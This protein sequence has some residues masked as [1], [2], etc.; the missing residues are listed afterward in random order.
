MTMIDWP[1]TKIQEK[2]MNWW[3]NECDIEGSGENF[4]LTYEY[5]GR[6]STYNTFEYGFEGMRAK[7]YCD[8]MH[9]WYSYIDWHYEQLGLKE[10]MENWEALEEVYDWEGHHKRELEYMFSEDFHENELFPETT[11]YKHEEVCTG[12]TESVSQVGKFDSNIYDYLSL[13]LPTKPGKRTKEHNKIDKKGIHL[14]MMTKLL[15]KWKPIDINDLF[16]RA[17]IEDNKDWGTELNPMKKPIIT[18]D[19]KDET[20]IEL[21][22]RELKTMIDK[23]CYHEVNMVTKEDEQEEKHYSDE[24]IDVLMNKL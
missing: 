23:G 10:K 1:L 4:P 13:K 16:L 9:N 5:H 7:E 15:T 19:M 12:A 17:K 2:T 22:K 24:N 11:N 14:M 20:K 8:Y 6:D 21:L 18:E 3:D